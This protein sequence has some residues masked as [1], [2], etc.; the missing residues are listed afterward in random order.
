MRPRLHRLLLTIAA[1]GAGGFLA[2]SQESPREVVEYTCSSS[3]SIAAFETANH[4]ASGHRYVPGAQAVKAVCCGI[5]AVLPEARRL[6]ARIALFSALLYTEEYSTFH[7]AALFQAR[8][9]PFA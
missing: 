8:A 9:P 5:L 6:S 3:Y 1:I 4:I 2:F 7:R